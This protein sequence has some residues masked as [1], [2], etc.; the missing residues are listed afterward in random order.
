MIIDT[1]I[2]IYQCKFMNL[3]ASCTMYKLLIL[4]HILELG[5]APLEQHMKTAP[6]ITCPTYRWFPYTHICMD[7]S[8][9]MHI[10]YHV[11]IFHVWLCSWGLVVYCMSQRWCVGLQPD[12]YFWGVKRYCDF[13]I[14]II[15]FIGDCRVG[16]VGYDAAFTQ[17]R[18]RV[19]LPV[20]VFWV[21]LW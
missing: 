21:F 5:S 16:L 15:V 9:Y 8:E 19:Q 4:G 11:Y 2:K 18:Y 10:M 1:H 17:R 14:M 20:S 13:K 7:M 3:S 6:V 12:W